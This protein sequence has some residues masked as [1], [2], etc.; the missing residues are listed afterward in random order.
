MNDAP[1]VITR[2]APSPT[3]HLHLG[4]AY[5]AKCAH[6]FAKKH[7][8]RFLLRIEDIDQ[9][10][11]KDD[12][13]QAI[14]EDLTWVGL[15][16]ETPVRRQSEHMHDYQN[17]LD[18]L[19]QK[20]LLFPCFCTR[21]DIRREIAESGRAPHDLTAHSSEGPLYP[22]TCRAL[23]ATE[24]QENID[25]GKPFALRLDMEKSLALVG[26]ET[27]TWTDLEAGE[28]MAT[29]EILNEILGDVVLARKDIPTSYHLSVVIDD[30][31]QN[32]SHVIRGKDLFQATHL[33]RL[34]QFLLGYEPPLYLHHDLLTDENGWRYAKRDN[35]K[36]LK[37]MRE[38][39]EDIRSYIISFP[40]PAA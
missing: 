25:V 27:L 24:R 4:H 39:G 34:L 31:L 5:S 16:W 40:L 21:K 26:D 37:S 12:Y 15:T 1:Q 3:G 38:N 7:G 23:S 33:H 29:A 8:G 36:T 9:T 11:C 10:R 2:F 19:D 17:A 22:G 30:H 14:Y 32:I 35:S 28:Q 6:D 13:E 18:I 20:G